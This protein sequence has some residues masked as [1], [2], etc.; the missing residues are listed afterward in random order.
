[1][2]SYFAILCNT[3]QWSPIAFLDWGMLEE[4]GV[5]EGKKKETPHS[6]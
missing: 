1:M 5:L 2:V 3:L 4:E 6:I